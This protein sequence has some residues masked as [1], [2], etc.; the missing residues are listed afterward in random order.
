[1]T[2]LTTLA[3]TTILAGC[4]LAALSSAFADRP[5][6]TEGPPAAAADSSQGG[7]T[8]VVGRVLDAD[9][10]TV[11]TAG[12]ELLS[13][14]GTVLA[15]C[16]VGDDGHFHVQ[17]DS[18]R[19]VA[20]LQ[21]AEVQVIAVGHVTRRVDLSTGRNELS[22]DDR[23]VRMDVVL[24][25][26]RAFDVVVVDWERSPL[27][28][29]RVEVR[30][31]FDRPPMWEPP[32][33]GA[34]TTDGSGAGRMEDL[35]ASGLAEATVHLP[36][37]EDWF[38]TTI[39]LAE[40]RVTLVVPRPSSLR[41]E[42]P[43]DAPLEQRPLYLLA[44]SERYPKTAYAEVDT[45]GVATLSPLREGDVVALGLL[46]SDGR[47]GW[48]AGR[49]VVSAASTPA[50]LR[51]DS[52]AGP[53]HWTGPRARPS[54]RVDRVPLDLVDADGAPLTLAGAGFLAP[55]GLT[56]SWRKG[57]R[58]GVARVLFQNQWSSESALV[59]ELAVP[60]EPP[61]DVTLR[62]QRIE[63]ATATIDGTR[64]PW[65]VAWDPE[66]RLRPL[67]SVRFREVGL[68]EPHGGWTVDLRRCGRR[69]RFFAHPDH[70]FE[71][72]PIV[73]ELP[74]GRYEYGVDSPRAGKACGTLDVTAD[75]PDAV[76]VEFHGLG[77]AT[78][79]F[80][81]EAPV[82]SLALLRRGG[83]ALPGVGAHFAVE[84]PPGTFA[85]HGVLA[86]E[87]DLVAKLL[88]PDGVLA[89][90]VA[91]GRRVDAETIADLGEIEWRGSST[92][93]PRLRRS[94]SSHGVEAI[95]L[96]G[97]RCLFAGPFA[98]GDA[99]QVPAGSEVRIQ[100]EPTRAGGAD[101]YELV[102]PVSAGPSIV[103]F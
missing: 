91:E 96:S 35:P 41:V 76:D 43:A 38:R 37:L 15:Q 90:R 2:D 72:A 39:D 18:T 87:Y 53:S 80:E 78:V 47:V 29:A 84:G 68:P 55:V 95:V 10:A 49:T 63:I 3:R 71:G 62:W 75:G 16:E 61:F 24:A 60:A 46:S 30:R 79:R 67:R 22:D 4:A 17:H 36:G 101:G 89:V 93:G 8:T 26:G 85:F 5:P 44:L 27:S 9:G 74:P 14:D 13:A 69:E 54:E 77:A 51:V 57:A 31:R 59:G 45:D 12:V 92:S 88:L 94:P 64:D 40:P 98:P 81:A 25:S 21:P 48:L 83:A 6:A 23:Y 52:I 100:V 70:R 103:E 73:G 19:S 58:S 86:G 102:L 99:L 82:I 1:M 28:G 33:L 42:L 34:V 97:D 50:V 20:V 66:T 11:A 32:P 65:K 7:F 56:A